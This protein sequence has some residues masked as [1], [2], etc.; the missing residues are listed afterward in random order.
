MPTRAPV[1]AL[2]PFF[3]VIVGC[4]GIDGESKQR[5]DVR[6]AADIG[7]A[8]PAEDRDVRTRI[9]YPLV[10]FDWN[11]NDSDQGTFRVDVSWP[12]LP[13]AEVEVAY[14]V[15]SDKRHETRP[16]GNGNVVTGPNPVALPVTFQVEG[17]ADGEVGINHLLIAIRT[18]VEGQEVES[19]AEF[20]GRE[21]DSREGCEIAYWTFHPIDAT[22][23][24]APQPQIGGTIGFKRAHTASGERIRIDLEATKVMLLD[25]GEAEVKRAW[26]WVSSE[27]LLPWEYRHLATA[28]LSIGQRSSGEEA[29][30]LDGRHAIPPPPVFRLSVK[31]LHMC[32]VA[33]EVDA[34]GRTLFWRYWLKAPI[35]VSQ[36][37]PAGIVEAQ[38]TTK[39]IQLK[40]L[41]F[42]RTV[43]AGVRVG[44]NDH[45]C[46]AELLPTN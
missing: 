41:L 22:G 46:P 25:V 32:I 30:M 24:V 31:E 11:A 40:P 4:A 1:R 20:S 37:E 21:D 43:S 35:D 8:E 13:D 27:P 36:L 15:R 10:H 3:L 44:A 19:F 9:G 39:S 42:H 23:L 26:V 5:P 12:S 6:A 34:N 33:E 14:W 18:E 7:R 29:L 17:I 38:V 45:G 2:W 16:F 28:A